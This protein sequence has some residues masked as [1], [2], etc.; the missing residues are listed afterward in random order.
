MPESKPV[1]L[2]LDD[3]PMVTATI[4]AAGEYNRLSTSGNV[5][6]LDFPKRGDKILAYVPSSGSKRTL[7][8]RGRR[9]ADGCGAVLSRIRVPDPAVGK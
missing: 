6:T 2:V 8:L 3:E 4:K 5:Q 1:I 9:H 7:C